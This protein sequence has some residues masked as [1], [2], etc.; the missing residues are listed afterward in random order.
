ML[1]FGITNDQI[2]YLLPYTEWHS[3]F[4]ENEEIVSCGIEAAPAVVD[5]YYKV[6]NEVK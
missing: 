3:Y 2:G 4:T 1:V 5:A 6:F